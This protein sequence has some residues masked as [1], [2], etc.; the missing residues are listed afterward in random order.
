M[1]FSGRGSEILDFVSDSA[2]VKP[3]SQTITMYCPVSILI[4]ICPSAMRLDSSK[5]PLSGA[6]IVDKAEAHI[7][8]ISFTWQMKGKQHVPS[9]SSSSR[10]GFNTLVKFPIDPLS[11]RLDIQ[12]SPDGAL[13]GYIAIRCSIYRVVS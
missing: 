9:Q 10:K 11:V 12:Q 4:Y 6:F 7:G 5:T 2:T 13:K 3:G 8:Q 1:T